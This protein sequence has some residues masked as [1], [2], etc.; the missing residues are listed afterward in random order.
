MSQ[1]RVSDIH[2]LKT[3][4]SGPFVLLQELTVT[5]LTHSILDEIPSCVL[6]GKRVCASP[7]RPL[8]RVRVDRLNINGISAAVYFTLSALC[9]ID[10]NL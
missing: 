3:G 10:L 2:A 9:V 5:G 7:S 1:H 4:A 8:N 6:V